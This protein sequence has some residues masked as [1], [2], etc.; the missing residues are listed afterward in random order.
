MTEVPIFRTLIV[1]CG[2]IAGGHNT[3]P[4]LNT[5]G[6]GI[7]AVPGL[8]LVGC[9]DVDPI[10][11]RSFAQKFHTTDFTS[12]SSAI[13][14]SRPDVVIVASSTESHRT[15][16]DEVLGAPNSPKVIV[17][18]KPAASNSEDYEKL[19]NTVSK[20][21][22]LCLVNMTRGSDA[23]LGDSFSHAARAT[24]VAIMA[25]NSTGVKR[26]NAA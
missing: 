23:G 4:L 21:D 14:L 3:P 17:L 1:G 18:E 8:A 16:V 10:A 20:S 7:R 26:P 5:H 11:A 9:V 13:E 6:G 15:V 25:S 22:A 12:I 2:A 19:L 24:G